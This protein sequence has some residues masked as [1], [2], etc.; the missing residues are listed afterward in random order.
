MYHVYCLNLLILFCVKKILTIS[1]EIFPYKAKE[2]RLQNVFWN[3]SMNYKCCYSLM[4]GLSQTRKQV[5]IEMNK[6]LKTL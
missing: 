5:L 4:M 3:I 1:I 6:H 2:I